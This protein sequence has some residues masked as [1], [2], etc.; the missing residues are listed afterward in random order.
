MTAQEIFTAATHLATRATD[1][2][3]AGFISATHAREVTDLTLK[4]VEDVV[5]YNDTDSAAL[6]IEEAAE[7]LDL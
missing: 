2:R 5:R 6:L 3:H 4:A 1:D 7:L